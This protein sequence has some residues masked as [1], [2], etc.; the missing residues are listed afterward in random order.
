MATL[1]TRVGHVS[2][3]NERKGYELSAWIDL[4]NKATLVIYGLQGI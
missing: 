4:N 3:P 2:G 1:T